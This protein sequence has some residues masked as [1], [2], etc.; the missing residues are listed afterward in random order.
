MTTDMALSL[1]AIVLGALLLYFGAEWLVKGSAGLAS[2]L[3][4]RPL[5]IGLTVVAYGTSAPELVVS[6]IAA[7]EGRS[8]IALGNVVGSN[9]ANLGLILGMTAVIAPLQIEGR[10]IRRE[11]PFLI[12]SVL[13]VPAMLYDGSV[14][15]L[16]GLLLVAAATMFTLITIRSG[17]PDPVPASK[18]MEGDAEAAGA[19]HVS[20]KT[21]LALVTLVGLLLLIGGGKVFVDGASALALLWGM[22]ERVVGLTIVAVGTSLPELAAS[23]VAAVRGHSSIAV[24]NVIGS[25][26]FNVF[27]VLGISSSIRPIEASLRGQALDLTVL[28][29]ITLFGVLMVRQARDT[30]RA[31]GLLLLVVYAAFLTALA[32]G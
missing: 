6:V 32:L 17:L 19:P 18:L 24:G 22:S 5:I 31:E 13:V 21:K 9:I 20:G 1:G 12:A 3:G 25:N 4:I 28:G 16:D 2:L 29:G 15:R 23:V 11:A 26:I 30:T 14:S 8:A 7:L 27:L 10:I